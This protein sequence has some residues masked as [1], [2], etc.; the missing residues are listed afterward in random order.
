[1]KAVDRSSSEKYEWGNNCKS[2][3]LLDAEKL[4]IKSELVPTSGEIG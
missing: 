4:N 1:M 3:V 2:R